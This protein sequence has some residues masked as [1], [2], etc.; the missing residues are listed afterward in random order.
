MFILCSFVLAGTIWITPE[1]SYCLDALT[2]HLGKP[3]HNPLQTTQPYRI[4]PARPTHSFLSHTGPATF[5]EFLCF[6]FLFCFFTQSGTTDTELPP[7][8]PENH[9]LNRRAR[10]NLTTRYLQQTR[11]SRIFQPQFLSNT[12]RLRGSRVSLF[13]ILCLFH[14]PSFYCLTPERRK[15][16]ARNMTGGEGHTHASTHTESESERELEP[17]DEFPL[18]ADTWHATQSRRSFFFHY[19]VRLHITSRVSLFFFVFVFF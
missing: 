19:P 14:F 17:Q 15:R 8:G 11:V 10:G 2:A 18:Q 5:A 7:D 4:F 16:V 6:C 3:R 1:A 9:I 13:I 12:V